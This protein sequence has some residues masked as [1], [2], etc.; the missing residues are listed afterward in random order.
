MRF[1][2]LLPWSF[3]ALLAVALTSACGDDAGPRLGDVTGSVTAEGE[4]L[5]GVNVTAPGAQAVTAVDGTFSLTGVAAGSQTVSIGNFPADVAFAQ[6][7][8]TVTVTAGQTV[9]ASFQG[10]WIRSSAIRGTV[11]V[12]VS[13]GSP[14]SAAGFGAVSGSVLAV[15]D[16]VTVTLEGP[17]ARNTTTDAGGMYA[18]DNIRAGSYTVSIG[19]FD[20]G[21]YLFATTSRSVD[22]AVNETRTADFAGTEASTAKLVA[23]VVIDAQPADAVTVS[24]A[25]PASRSLPTGADGIALFEQLPR[26]TYEVTLQ[27]TPVGAVFEA[28]TQTVTI[29]AIGDSVAV[30]FLGA[31]GPCFVARIIAVGE[32]QAGQLVEG[33]CEP[34]VDDNDQPIADWYLDWFVLS[35]AANTTVQIDLA[36]GGFD[37]FLFLFRPDGTEVASDNNGG[38]GVN[39]TDARI[40][41][42]LAPGDYQIAAT[43][44]TATETGSYQISVQQL[45]A[46]G[47]P[48]VLSNF[49]STLVQVN[50]QTN[51]SEQTPVGSSFNFDLDYSDPDGDMPNPATLRVTVTGRP[52][53]QTTPL[54]GQIALNGDGSAGS[55]AFGLCVLFQADSA[56]DISVSTN[57]AAGNASNAVTTRLSQPTGANVGGAGAPAGA[58]PRTEPF[59]GWILG[60]GKPDGILGT[61]AVRRVIRPR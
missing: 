55:L 6:T 27:N 8:Q 41:T 4:P 18:F 43:S 46:T 28:D 25:G 49:T 23:E 16:G 29:P 60:G 3:A 5:A 10:T 17:D 12:A 44:F 36:S 59:A 45:S 21:D 11:T 14:P 40:V 47:S 52:S 32:T 31:S 48:P 1:P 61:D 38:G 51:C 57:D 15:P 54:S 30:T 2:R 39:G 22:V 33:D 9:T 50:D 19:G 53:G 34:F 24:I 58:I 20:A 35:V 26:G 42:T 13:S 56:L 37:A 7:S